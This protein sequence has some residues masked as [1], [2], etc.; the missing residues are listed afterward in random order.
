MRAYF[1]TNM[2]LS[3]IQQGIQPAHVIGEMSVKYYA[4]MDGGDE[5]GTPFYQWAD[6]HKTMI[7]LNG[8]FSDNLRELVRMFEKKGNPYPW[9][10]FNEGKD[11]LDGALTCVGI[12]LP[13]KI[14]ETAAHLRSLRYRDRVDESAQI[15][16]T[17]Q[18]VMEDAT[19]SISKWEFALIQEL[20]N[21]GLAK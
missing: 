2:Y 10:Y 3:S 9:A 15:I 21:Y 14:Y 11:A 5:T 6:S 17:G 12:I 20:E 18:I 16:E 4:A 7:C 13:P 1:F 19:H 8:G